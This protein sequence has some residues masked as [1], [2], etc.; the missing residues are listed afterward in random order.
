MKRF[1]NHISAVTAVILLSVAGTAVA[2]VRITEERPYIYVRH[3]DRMVRVQRIQDEQHELEGGFA[4]TSRKCPP[5]CITPAIPAPGVHSMGE[6]E[7]FDFLR[8]K[9]ETGRGL[10][11]DARTSSFFERGTIPGSVSIP[12]TRFEENPESEALRDLL[13]RLGAKPV[14]ERSVS[15]WE[16]LRNLIG[17]A[18]AAEQGAWDFSGAKELALWCNGPWCDQSPRA[19]KA[20]VALGYP[21]DKLHYYRGGMQNWTNCS[22]P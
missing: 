22:S 8:H 12:F 13:I 19:I 6:L 7:I 1:M 18:E 17:T 15:L 20:L 9:A 10:L 14:T 2:E 3:D 16:R 21:P 5:F 11:V 4:R